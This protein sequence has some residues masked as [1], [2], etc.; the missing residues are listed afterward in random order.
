MVPIQHVRIPDGFQ[1]YNVQAHRPLA[2]A[3]APELLYC[4]EEDPNSRPA[5][6]LFMLPN[7]RIYPQVQ[8]AGY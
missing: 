5:H 3:D 7:L 2:S 8:T 1:R 4:S 6:H